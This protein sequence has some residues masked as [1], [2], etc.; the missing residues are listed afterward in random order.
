MQL[1]CGD[2]PLFDHVQRGAQDFPGPQ[3]D[4]DLP[5]PYN[6]DIGVMGLPASRAGVQCLELIQAVPRTDA[7]SDV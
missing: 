5:G 1:P 6:D 7:K 2:V 4:R 3:W